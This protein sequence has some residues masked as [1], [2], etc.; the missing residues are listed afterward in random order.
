MSAC[1]PPE[2]RGSRSSR[3]ASSPSRPRWIGAATGRRRTELAKQCAIMNCERI[4]KG[5]A[6]ELGA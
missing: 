2:P 1:G 4:K 5:D 3:T 6:R